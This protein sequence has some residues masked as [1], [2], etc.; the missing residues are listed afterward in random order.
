MAKSTVSPCAKPCVVWVCVEVLV[1]KGAGLLPLSC[2]VRFIR[3][4]IGLL[5]CLQL[6]ACVSPGIQSTNDDARR[7]QLSGKMGI[8]TAKLAE[9]ASINWKQCGE[10]FDVRLTSPLGQTVARVEGRGEKLTVWMD[11]HE[12]VVTAQPEQLLQEQLGWSIPIRALRYWVRGER[13]PGS[14]AQITGPAGQPDALAQLDWQVRYPSWHQREAVALPAKVLI[15]DPQV[16]A[17]LLIR[18]WVL[19]DAVECAQ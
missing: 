1:F 2:C 10:Q 9:S 8:K 19:G 17:T 5:C 7:W 11:G 18:E 6:A 4:A 13:A 15:N 16:Q 3:F 12:P 14:P